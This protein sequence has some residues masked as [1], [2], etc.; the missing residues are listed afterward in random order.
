MCGGRAKSTCGRSSRQCGGEGKCGSGVTNVNA[1]V[2]DLR[3]GAAV[4]GRRSER[5][6]RKRRERRAH[7]RHDV[8]ADDLH[9]FERRQAVTVDDEPQHHLAAVDAVL[10]GLVR[11][12]GR[13]VV[14][15]RH[16]VDHGHSRKI[17]GE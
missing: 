16:C 17:C 12:L 7:E 3:H 9:R 6:R 13:R 5:L 15:A 14:A 2:D 8:R 10:P 4:D 11:K 1:I